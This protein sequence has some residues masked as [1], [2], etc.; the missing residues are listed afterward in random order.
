MPRVACAGLLVAD[1]FVP[2]LDRLPNAGELVA[3][4]D[5]LVQPGGG[6]SNTAVA[7]RRQGCDVA[8]V[9]CVGDDAF[10]EIVEQGL[11]GHGIDTTGI[12][13][14]TGTGTAKTVILPVAGED[15]RYIHAFGANAALGVAD[16]GPAAEHADLLHV[17]G[18]LMLP[19]LRAAELASALAGIRSSGTRVVLDV[20]V[21]AG[22][23]VS[24]DDVAA[25]LPHL[26][27][28]VVNEDEARALTG[29]ADAEGQAAAIVAAGAR[30]VALTR[31]EHGAVVAVEGER[32]AVPA[33]SVAVVDPSGAGDAFAAGLISSLL[34]G[35]DPRACVERASALG[36]SACTA[37][38]CSA[39]VFTREQLD[40]FMAAAR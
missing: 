36:A 20:A 27:W 29:E 8:V 12:R 18:Y 32:F 34:D 24:L 35:H 33:P 9:G 3:T 14:V 37:L 26:D 31:G 13:R 40:E 11:Q 15:R 5:F 17:G 1:V 2:P 38:G 22:A 25:V 7:L 6:A 10:G 39:G 21:P 16:L 28:F 4:G 30:A 19:G 23:Q